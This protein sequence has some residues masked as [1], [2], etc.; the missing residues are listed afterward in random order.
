MIL[1][2]SNKGGANINNCQLKINKNSLGLNCTSQPS[3]NGSIAPNASQTVRVSLKLDPAFVKDDKSLSVQMA[4]KTELGVVFF[5]DEIDPSIL[6][7]AQKMETQAYGA[8]WKSLSDSDSLVADQMKDISSLR[9]KYETFQRQVQGKGTMS[10]WAVTA[11][12]S[13]VMVQ[14]IILPTGR[15]KITTRSQDTITAKLVSRVVNAMIS[16]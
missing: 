11:N 6:L 15:C 1:T 13:L 5:R 8:Q 2:L 9:S 10:F 3:L 12:G 7:T 16:P 4:L 14:L